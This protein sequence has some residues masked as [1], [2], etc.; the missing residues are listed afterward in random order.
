MV[1][2]NVEGVFLDLYDLDPPKLNFAIEDITDTTARST[3]SR[4]FRVPATSNN[5][6]FFTNAYQ[7]NG[8]DFDV[9]IKRTS[10]IYIDGSL[11]ST[12]QLR[13]NKIYNSREGKRIDYECIFFGETKDLST[14][15]GE[16]YLN[17]LDLSA[18]THTLSY[19]AITKSWEAYPSGTTTDGLF[20]GD[21]LYPL[22]DYGNTY[23]NGVVNETMVQQDNTAGVPAFTKLPH[24]LTEDRWKPLVRAKLLFDTIFEEAGFTYDS[25]LLNSDLFLPIYVSAFG[26]EASIYTPNA[27]NTCDITVNGSTTAAVIVPYNLKIFDYNNRFTIDP[28][29]NTYEYTVPLTGTYEIS[30]SINGSALTSTSGSISG[31]LRLN[32]A[33]TIDSDSQSI[34]N[35]GSQE[36]PESVSYSLNS[37][38]TGTLTAGQYLHVDI[39]DTNLEN[40][41]VNGGDFRVLSAP[42][43]VSLPSVLDNNY[44]KIDFIRDI[45]TM[46]RLVLVPDNKR[47]NHFIIEPWQD[48]IATGE[49]MDW[50]HK[51]DL[52]KD[53]ITEPLFYTQS[54]R[55]NFN[56][57]EG[58][59]YLNVINEEQFKEVFGTAIVN[60]NNDL[61]EGERDITTNFTPTPITQIKRKNL[62]IGET[63]IIPQ[64]HA[65]E[66]GDNATYNPQHVSIR[67]NTR[68]LYYNGIKDTDGIDW[69]L[70]NDPNSPYDYYPMVSFYQDFPNTS[71]S[72]NLNWQIEQGYIQHAV[73]S[74]LL[75]KSVY[76]KYWSNYINSIYDGFAR[77]VTAHFVLDSVDLLDFNF[78]NVIFVKDAYYYVNR[79]YDVSI[80]QKSSVKVDLIKLINYNVNEG[81]F[82]PPVLV[83]NTT[84][85]DWEDTNVNWE[86]Y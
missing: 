9:R 8:V 64:I 60:G 63:F 33:V 62:S 5:N 47:S 41:N 73:N 25:E 51:L 39:V 82:V 70:E 76:D 2:L 16:G 79:I 49:V 13:L 61:L 36:N 35:P 78:D 48:Y 72:L 56:N 23:T 52:N 14:S 29:T 19:T 77:K 18:Y 50:T 24:P 30:W 71:N 21:I 45:I 10:Y 26:N 4:T 32:N 12:G 66:P 65:N 44:K 55:I 1:Q 53:L 80:G 17:E 20:N 38:W 75:G 67:G 42:G 34:V 54:S 40:Y 7:I 37:V 84:D 83:W 57:K 68:I 43:Q 15:I 81:G 85:S 46:F 69:Y 28:L 58:K 31:R 59:D 11:F 74:P 6:T 3:F 86:G 22:I 27:N